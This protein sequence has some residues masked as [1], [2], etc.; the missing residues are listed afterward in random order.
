MKPTPTATSQPSKRQFSRPTSTEVQNEGPETDGSDSDAER[1]QGKDMDDEHSEEKGGISERDE[2]NGNERKHAEASP[3]KGKQ[4]LTSKACLRPTLLISLDFISNMFQA[5]V[6]VEDEEPE[7]IPRSRVKNK[8]LPAMLIAGDVWTK[9]V[10]PTLF[11]WLAAQADPWAPTAKYLEDAIRTIGRRYVDEDYDLEGTTSPEFQ[12]V[13][14]SFS[15]S[16][17]ADHFVGSPT[18]Q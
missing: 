8:D 6:K 13:L 5:L 16:L 17:V 2:R 14:I 11:R 1:S 9:Q 4:R 7:L 18:V 15:L 12:L 10:M 3:I